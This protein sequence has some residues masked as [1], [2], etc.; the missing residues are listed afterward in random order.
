M[1]RH[2]FTALPASEYSPF[3]SADEARFYHTIDLPK[4]G[5]RTGEWDL[6]GSE[7]AYLGG[8][9][10]SGKTFFDCGTASGFM[11]FEMERRGAKVIALDLDPDQSMDMGLVPY[12][13]YEKAVGISWDEAIKRRRNRQVKMRQGFLIGRKAFGSRVELMIG[14]I[15]SSSVPVEADGALFGAI[16][17]HLRD[18]VA[19]LY[20][21][22]TRVR[23]TIII[24]EP[25]EID[26]LSL[27]APPVMLFRPSPMDTQNAGTWWYM[28]P[29]FFAKALQVVGFRDFAVTCH[30]VK[31]LD[32]T[33]VPTFTLVARR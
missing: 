10:V 8:V 33:T 31:H 24:S 3:M 29:G 11:S 6:R 4:I 30:Q 16:L 22:A 23:E 5:L 27:D 19:A 1:Q 2:S 15:M 17:L 32:R 20:N 7:T 21:V 25:L 18:P 14:N 26:D 13:D 9:H 12:H 28:S